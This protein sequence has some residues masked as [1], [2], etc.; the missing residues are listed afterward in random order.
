MRS[1][2]S[3]L[4]FPVS[5]FLL[6]LTVILLFTS[7]YYFYHKIQDNKQ[8]PEHQVKG[9]VAAMQNTRDS[10]QELYTATIK[11]LDI[12]IDSTKNNVDTLKGH[13]QNK[14]GESEK[15]RNEIAAILKDH[16]P[17]GVDMD[18]A[19]QK[20]DEL[21]HKVDELHD[22]NTAVENENK[23]LKAALDQL[24]SGMQGMEQN[25]KRIGNGNKV[26][27]DKAH[28]SIVVSELQLSAVKINDDKEEETLLAQQTEKF[29]GSF[30][31]KDDNQDN[32]IEMIVVVLQPDG[33]VLQKSTWESGTFDTREGRK[34]YSCKLHSEYNRGEVKRLFFSLSQ[35]IFSKGNYSMQIYYKGMMVGR[36]FKTLS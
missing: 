28:P 35:D 16:T 1:T 10:L 33:K 9:A 25:I 5:I 8:P 29:V 24:T 12:Q 17:G 11:A 32:T 3:A 13:L 27:T 6:S 7:G 30:I 19:R 31:V 21:K 2:K 23:K 20:I 22:L 15:L 18:I 14:L 26:L 36:M 34:L 4:L